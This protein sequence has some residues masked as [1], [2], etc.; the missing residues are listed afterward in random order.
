M[1][2]MDYDRELLYLSFCCQA[3]SRAKVLGTDIAICWRAWNCG[4]AQSSYYPCRTGRDF[5]SRQICNFWLVCLL[6]C[7]VWYTRL[8]MCSFSGGPQKSIRLHVTGINLSDLRFSYRYYTNGILLFVWVEPEQVNYEYGS[9]PTKA[10]K[11]ATHCA[12]S[13]LH[14][15][16]L[17]DQGQGAI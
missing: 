6:S 17:Q 9:S 3:T 2:T 14:G 11:P 7:N 5:Y 8:E 10:E 1:Y 4:A 15:P 16:Y 13:L 12:G